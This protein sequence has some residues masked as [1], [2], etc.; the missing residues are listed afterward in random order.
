MQKKNNKTNNTHIDNFI[1]KQSRTL[2][3]K[4]HMMFNSLVKYIVIW[5]MLSLVAENSNGAD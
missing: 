5:D 2:N 1:A 3:M 4:C